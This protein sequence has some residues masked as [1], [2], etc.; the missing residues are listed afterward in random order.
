LLI[1]LDA[2]AAADA[3]LERV[4]LRGDVDVQR[5]SIVRAYR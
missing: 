4:G 3:V 2:I 5:C 1:E